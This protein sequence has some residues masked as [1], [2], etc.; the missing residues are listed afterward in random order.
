[1]MSKT[2][3]W[4]LGIVLGLVVLAGL[5]FVAA[6]YF[7]F[8]HM[9]FLSGPAYAGRPMMNEYGFGNRGP[10]D[11]FRDFRQPM[12]GRRGFGGYGFFGLPFLFLGGFLRLIIPLGLLALVAFFAYRIGRQAGLKAALATPV[13]TPTTE[14]KPQEPPQGP[15]QTVA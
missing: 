11:G 10:M 13:S 7:G 14:T 4:I 15:N 12:M 5:G 1:M 6:S 9:S 3:K 2:W 8:G